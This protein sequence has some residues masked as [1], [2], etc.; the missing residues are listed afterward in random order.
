MV[1]A[2]A[3]EN[4]PGKLT[5]AGC[6]GF[7]DKPVIESE[8]LAVLQRHLELE[9]VAELAVPA[10]AAHAPVSATPAA[11]E[12]LVI[13]VPHLQALLPL[14]RLGHA[15]GVQRALDTLVEENGALEPQVVQMRAL[16]ARFAWGELVEYLTA[17]LQRAGDTTEATA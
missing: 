15:R 12:P 5:E 14:A 10:W 2:N 1:S 9:W 3:F 11:A 4:Q 7:V 16:A 13:P 8:L 6:Q 17:E